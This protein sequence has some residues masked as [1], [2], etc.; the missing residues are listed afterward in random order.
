MKK[1]MQKVLP[2]KPSGLPFSFI[3]GGKSSRKIVKN[4]KFSKNSEKIDAVRN[5]HT[6][7]FKDP[8]TG[9]ELI[10]E[11]TEYADFPALE[12]VLNFKN[13]G[14]SDTPILEN[15]QALDLNF[16][17]KEADEYI[18]YHTTGS[19]AAK[20]DFTPMQEMLKPR[21]SK[22]LYSRCGRS[23]DGGG[24]IEP[25]I[26]GS[27]PFFNLVYDNGGIIFAVGWSGQWISEFQRNEAKELNVTAGM[28]FTR[29][30]LLPVFL[31]LLWRP[32]IIMPVIKSPVMR[33]HIYNRHWQCPE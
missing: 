25:R 29:L 16:T 21:R 13:H 23:S 2:N 27:F 9:L 24:H 6:M 10:C 28:E 17:R 18:L 4:W 11:A 5:L 14:M 31:T 15:V 12:W 32:R 1:R 7:T 20:S 22:R 19:C 8:E 3:Y 30:K 26:D 33:I